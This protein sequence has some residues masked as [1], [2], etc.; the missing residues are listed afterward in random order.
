VGAVKV[1]PNERFSRVA[2]RLDAVSAGLPAMPAV[3]SRATE[4]PSHRPRVCV[5][6]LRSEVSSLRL[7]AQLGTSA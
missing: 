3:G 2:D 1:D 4:A 7:A 5:D 6:I